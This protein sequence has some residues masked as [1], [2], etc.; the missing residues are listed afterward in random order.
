MLLRGPGDIFRAVD[1][2]HASPAKMLNDS[3]VRNSAAEH[4]LAG[5]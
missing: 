1:N 2:T 5:A 3:I 4:G